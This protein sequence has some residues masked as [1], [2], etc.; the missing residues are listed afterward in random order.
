MPYKIQSEHFTDE[1]IKEMF[2]RAQGQG[3]VVLDERLID[4]YAESLI[5]IAE[6]AFV[7]G[8]EKRFEEGK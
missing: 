1:D 7:A 5:F 8:W 2:K 3:M 4:I 6:A